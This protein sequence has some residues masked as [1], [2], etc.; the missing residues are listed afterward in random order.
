[1]KAVVFG[2]GGPTGE[3]IALELAA[4]GHEVIAAQR[5]D[6]PA[7]KLTQAGVRIVH[8]DFDALDTIT[9][10]LAD[11]DIAFFAPHLLTSV[12]ARAKAAAKT[13]L[14]F[15]SSNTVFAAPGSQTARALADCEHAIL[16]ARPDALILRPTLIYGDPRQPTI[17]RL[18]AMAR[19]RAILP[20]PGLGFERHQPVFVADLARLAV[21]AGL[22][23]GLS[24]AFGVGGAEIVRAARMYRTIARVA[25]G[26]AIVAPAPKLVLQLA[27]RVR[28]L[29]L[30]DEQIARIGRDRI[31]G[32]PLPR[33]FQARVGWEEGLRKLLAAMD[34]S[35]RT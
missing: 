7:P 9:S 27:S 24:G 29:P 34:Q 8:A 2:A 5:R 14:V 16:A 12:R 13:R 33:Q 25:G 31:A 11:A 30:D 21:E 22:E 1:M 26:R 23:R 19:T 32:A 4:L 15:F 35:A 10:A 28:S 17:T 3:A 6:A 18:L 20:M